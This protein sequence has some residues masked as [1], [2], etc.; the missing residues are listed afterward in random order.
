MLYYIVDLNNEN[1]NIIIHISYL[2]RFSQNPILGKGKSSL[3]FFLLKMDVYCFV[4][5]SFMITRSTTNN[6]WFWFPV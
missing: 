3:L 4:K 5:S 6:K 1:L 2:R